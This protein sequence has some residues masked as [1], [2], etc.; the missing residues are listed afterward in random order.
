MLGGCDRGGVAEPACSVRRPALTSPPAKRIHSPSHAHDQRSPA[1]APW[2]PALS[3]HERKPVHSHTETQPQTELLPRLCPALLNLPA[4]ADA[5]PW[6]RI[7]FCA[8][9]QSTSSSMKSPSQVSATSRARTSSSGVRRSVRSLIC[10][11][12]GG[13]SQPC[14]AA[15]G[16]GCGHAG[17]KGMGG[18]HA[19]DV[20]VGDADQNAIVGFLCQS[21]W[22]GWS[23]DAGAA[24]GRAESG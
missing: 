2:P 9:A 11:A 6:A 22:T 3:K 24:A 16:G 13:R 10:A 4:H 20:L 19:G 14:L 1:L 23:A 21:R 18:T 15:S 5:P 12:S 7:L 17:R 8:P